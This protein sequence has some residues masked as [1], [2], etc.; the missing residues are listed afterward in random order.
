MIYLDNAATT[1]IDGEVLDAMLPYITNMYG[2]AGALYEL[3]RQAKKAV[4]EARENVAG[5]LNC[6]PDQVIFTS[7]GSEGNNFV[8]SGLAPHLKETG[9]PE[10]ITSMGEHDSVIRATEAL[11]IKHG[12]HTQYLPI[13]STGTVDMHDL[14]KAISG[15]TGLVSIMYVNNELGTVNP[16]NDIAAVCAKHGILFH[17]DCVQAASSRR[18]DTREIGCDFLTV[19]SHKLHGPKGVGAVF[20]KDKSLLS[21]LV[22]GG[23]NQEFGYRGGTENVAGIVGF[24]KACEIMSRNF[25]E[26]DLRVSMMKQKFFAALMESL[27]AYKLGDRAHV[28][29]E[30]VLHH[31]KILNMRFD[32]IDSETL[33][34]MLDAKGVCVSAGSACHS[35]EVEPSRVLLAY[36]VGEDAARSSVRISFSKK[37]TVDE[38]ESAAK[39]MADC[40]NI[41]AKV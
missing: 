40:V 32:G 13:S 28:N 11:C 1:Q 17:T 31:G 38:V 23:E 12:F 29:G 3:G 34:L 15:S 30:P 18:L 21:P 24:G 10:I 8:L 5:F 39:I 19:S 2:N 6:E 16:V 14:S 36:G 33:L 20:A 26:I 35:Q 22:C 27:T 4:D 37:N 41:L 9:K 7:G 25:S